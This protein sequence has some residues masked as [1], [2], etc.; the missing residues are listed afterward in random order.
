MLEWWSDKRSPI[1]LKFPY[2]FP[3]LSFPSRIAIMLLQSLLSSST[4]CLSV[5][6]LV[7]PKSLVARE[8]YDRLGYGRNGKALP[9]LFSAS[10]DEI[11]YGLECGTFT[12]V[13]LT[14]AYIARIEETNPL[15]HSVLEINPVSLL[16]LRR[17]RLTD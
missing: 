8:N 3:F 15:L 2:L 14:A 9:D 12:S 17:A 16:V 4:L 1:V 11:R 6:A 10:I 5:S 7:V 13:D